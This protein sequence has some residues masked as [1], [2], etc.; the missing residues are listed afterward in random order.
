MTALEGHPN[1]LTVT[2]AAARGVPGLVR[3]AENGEDAI[4]SRH[5]VPVAAVVSMD[6]LRRIDA[7]EADLRDVALVMTRMATDDGARVSL[8]DVIASFG[9]SPEELRA[10]LDADID[11]DSG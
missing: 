5:G 1:R 11:A 10:E 4:V 7:L 6:R 2:Q 8:E 3:D 9:Y